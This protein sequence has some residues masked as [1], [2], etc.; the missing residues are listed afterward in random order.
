MTGILIAQ[1]LIVILSI[2]LGY[3]LGSRRTFHIEED[4]S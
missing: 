1:S 2:L 4:D 3:G